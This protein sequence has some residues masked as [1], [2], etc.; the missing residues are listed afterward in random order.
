MKFNMM[1]SL[2]LQWSF[3]ARATWIK[4]T[5]FN[6]KDSNFYLEQCWRSSLST[7][8]QLPLESV[9]KAPRC[10]ALTG[11]RWLTPC[12]PGHGSCRCAHIPSW[13]KSSWRT[14]P[15]GIWFCCDPRR[16][17]PR[18]SLWTNRSSWLPW[19]VCWR[20]WCPLPGSDH[21]NS[22]QNRARWWP[23]RS[24]GDFRQTLHPIKKINIWLNIEF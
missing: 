18:M 15:S 23:T 21:V 5:N 24:N 8:S 10:L 13:A 4:Y 3:V 2:T 22:Q 19:P 20:L 16:T 6:L 17:T 11:R 9:C 1:N 14:S 12:W 7:G